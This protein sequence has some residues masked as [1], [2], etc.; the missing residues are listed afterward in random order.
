MPHEISADGVIKP[1]F[2]AGDAKT[3]LTEETAAPTIPPEFRL[4]HGRVIGI[5]TYGNA[6]A[7]PP[8][9]GQGFL[10]RSKVEFRHNLTRPLKPLVGTLRG[11]LNGHNRWLY[12]TTLEWSTSELLAEK[13]AAAN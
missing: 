10:G 12:A 5:Q 1:H 6:A 4:V 3:L 2:L 8:P 11:V 9:A 13:P 7:S